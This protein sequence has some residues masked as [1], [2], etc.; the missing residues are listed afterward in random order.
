MRFKLGKYAMELFDKNGDTLQQI[1]IQILYY[2]QV[3]KAN[4]M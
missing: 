1:Q 4:N 3:S 2:I